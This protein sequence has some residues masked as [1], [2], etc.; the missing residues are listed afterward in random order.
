[1]KDEWIYVNLTYI[2]N[3][4]VN[5]EGICFYNLFLNLL[6]NYIFC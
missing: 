2:I 1:M 3:V 5:F 4:N 6:K